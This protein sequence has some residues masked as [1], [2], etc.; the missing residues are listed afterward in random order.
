[1]H[2]V[3]VVL[4][5]V[6]VVSALRHFSATKAISAVVQFNLVIFRTVQK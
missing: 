3:V 2:V 1:M 4:V 6:V 5:V